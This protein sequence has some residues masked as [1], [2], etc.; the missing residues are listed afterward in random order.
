MASTQ[1]D[2]GTPVAN[3]RSPGNT[4]ETSI[5]AVIVVVAS[6]AMV[7]LLSAIAIWMGQDASNAE[8]V[9]TMV[10]PMIAAWVGTV[11]AYY[12]SKEN[13]AAAAKS[14]SQLVGQFTSDQR[15]TFIR[16][17]AAMI[18]TKDAATFTLERPETD[19]KL[20]ADLLDQYLVPKKRNRL[21]ILSPEGRI[22]F[23]VHRSLI[24]R[25]LVEQLSKGGD[26]SKL[27][28]NDL[29]LDPGVGGA[30]REAFGTVRPEATLADV[31]SQMDGIPNC[32]DVF[33]TEDGTRNS[34]VLGWL[35]NVIVAERARV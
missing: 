17:D 26:I 18:A 30:V 28:L 14:T 2:G 8:K 33:V 12:F 5:I 6:L 11:L 13:Y 20:K 16:A 21:P 10:L 4:S 22:K 32:A 31:K 15:L 1:A 27:S 7:A 24:D 35:T 34:R 29:L 25:F 23:I 9:L 3:G 19:V